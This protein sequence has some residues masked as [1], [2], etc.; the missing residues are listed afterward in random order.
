M[1]GAIVVVGC[2]FLGSIFTD[3]LLRRMFAGVLTNPL[4]FI[5]SDVWERRNAAN[6]NVTLDEASGEVP[7]AVTLTRRATAFEVESVAC[8]KRLELDS[9]DLIPSETALIVD[10]VDNLPT[11]HLLYQQ[12][13]QRG[14]PVLHVGISMSGLGAVEWSSLGID[15]FSLAPHKMLLAEVEDTSSQPKLPPCELVQLRG[16]GLNT[17]FAA[18]LAASIYLGFDPEE[19]VGKESKGWLTTWRATPQGYEAVKPL[20][21]QLL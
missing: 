14:V 3:E 2:G 5:D 10:A 8:H 21:E 13:L 17:G 15:T 7:K 9:L 19:H 4:C 6:Q 20:W 12:G 18:A 11:R 1:A 16:A